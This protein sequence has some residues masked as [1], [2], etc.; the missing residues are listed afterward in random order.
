MQ[1]WCVFMPTLMIQIRFIICLVLRFPP[2]KRYEFGSYAV[3]EIE[4][5]SIYFAWFNSL[6]WIK[7]NYYSIVCSFVSSAPTVIVKQWLNVHCADERHIVQR[8]ANERT[9]MRIKSNVHVIQMKRHNKLCYWLMNRHNWPKRKQKQMDTNEREL[10]KYQLYSGR[11]AAMKQLCNLQLHTH[12]HIFFFY[13][14]MNLVFCFKKSDKML[15]SRPPYFSFCQP[16]EISIWRIETE[17]GNVC[18]FAHRY[19]RVSIYL[20]K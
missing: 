2:Q 4:K 7:W 6:E 5:K 9:G 1:L 19:S 11:S 13:F 8:F 16:C 20:A 15:K 3:N 10:Q 18:T 14:N 12:T 17:T